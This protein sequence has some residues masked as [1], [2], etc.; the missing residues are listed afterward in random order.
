MNRLAR[1]S[2]IAAVSVLLIPVSH[3]EASS[4]QTDERGLIGR[5]VNVKD[6]TPGM[7]RVEISTDGSQ[8]KIHPWGQ[9][10][11]TE[12]DWKEERLHPVGPS[13]RGGSIQEGFAV[14]EKG[15][16]AIY[17]TVRMDGGQLV[18]E[19]LTIFKDGDKLGRSNNRRVERMRR[20]DD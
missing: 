2:L 6:Q 14:F 3:D 11:P 4:P 20:A 19:V 13:T 5:W 9:C 16:A 18:I 17:L 15:F 7:T 8:W 12:C 1:I 10:N